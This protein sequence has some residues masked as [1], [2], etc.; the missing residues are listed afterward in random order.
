MLY[1]I[2]CFIVVT[3]ILV[4]IFNFEIHTFVVDFAVDILLETS[5]ELVS[6]NLIVGYLTLRGGLV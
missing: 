4:F 3:V 2:Y 1:L 6:Q 5:M